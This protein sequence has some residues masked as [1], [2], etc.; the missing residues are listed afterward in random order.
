MAQA[1]SI[2]KEN[3]NKLWKRL[4]APSWRNAVWLA[5]EDADEQFENLGGNWD[6][7]IPSTA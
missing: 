4:P 5:N 3:V 2:F 6:T 7:K 1:G